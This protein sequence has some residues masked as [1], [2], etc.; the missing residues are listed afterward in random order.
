MKSTNGLGERGRPQRKSFGPLLLG[1]LILAAIAAIV[2]PFYLGF[3]GMMAGSAPQSAKQLAAASPGSQANVAIEVTSLPAQTMLEGNLLQKNADGTYSRTGKTISVKWG[4]S[5]FV[6]GGSS[7]IKVGA[8]L[9]A[10]G[11]LNP[12]DV[13]TAQQI[14]VLT[15]SVH[16][17]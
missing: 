5:K 13:L 8:I 14:V 12:S 6:M 3:S 17:K 4:G 1:V 10:S 2:I 11:I 7:D 16:I 9:Q 15:T